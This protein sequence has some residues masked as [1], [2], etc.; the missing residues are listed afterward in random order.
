MVTRV[1]RAIAAGGAAVAAVVVLGASHTISMRGAATSNAGRAA[2]AG[3][4]PAHTGAIREQTHHS[5]NG[6][7]QRGSTGRC[8]ASPG[9]ATLTLTNTLPRAWVPGDGSG[10]RW[11]PV[12]I[13]VGQELVV[14]VPPA[15]SGGTPTA[16]QRTRPAMLPEICHVTVPSRSVAAPGHPAHPSSGSRTVFIARQPGL[17]HLT[18]NMLPPTLGS[19]PGAGDVAGWSGSGSVLVVSAG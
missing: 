7:M 14:T 9:A 4:T 5:Q 15:G 8:Q 16:V 1:T 19:L 13:R 3:S 17:D 10:D 12:R 6:V 11:P 18:A 2:S